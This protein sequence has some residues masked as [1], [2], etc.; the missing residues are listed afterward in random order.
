MPVEPTD[1]NF[2]KFKQENPYIH[3]NLYTP[4]APD[5]EKCVITPLYV[6]KN[7]S[8]KIVNIL[9]YRLGERSHYAYIRNI[10]RLIYN[11]TKSHNKKFICPYCACTYF[12][13]QDALTNHLEKKHPYIGNE[14][15]CEKCLNIFHTQEAKV[16]HDS[17]C[18]VKESELC[19]VEYP[20]YD[21]PIHWEE[22]D[23]YMLS[24][25]P[26]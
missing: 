18:M 5:E 20:A 15:V 16:F 9:Y 8:T 21:R 2:K 11:S 7:R 19:V 12:N 3:L 17:I 10:S 23:N 13:S 22:W 26:T 1:K 14:F 24:R 25:I 4:P 6:G